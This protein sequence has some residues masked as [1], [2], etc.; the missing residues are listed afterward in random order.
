MHRKTHL[1]SL[2]S[3]S[4]VFRAVTQ[5][6]KQHTLV[7]ALKQGWAQCRP[8]HHT[9]QTCRPHWP[10]PRAV[11]CTT[12]SHEPSPKAA[13][14]PGLLF[15]P[16][17]LPTG[18]AS[19]I[20][21]RPASPFLAPSVNS[22]DICTVTSCQRCHCP[23]QQSAAFPHDDQCL[24]S[25]FL[26]KDRSVWGCRGPWASEPVFLACKHRLFHPQFPNDLEACY[27]I[28]ST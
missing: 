16:T 9:S 6:P 3:K 2:L 27:L 4:G 18:N 10:E 20:S 13:G 19:G 5:E 23:P 7:T 21:P 15:K 14:P 22:A 24:C 25:S 12:A 28:I 8:A 26:D 17:D 1:L 11:T